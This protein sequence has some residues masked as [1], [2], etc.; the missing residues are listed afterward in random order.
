MTINDDTQH[1]SDAAVSRPS[2][3]TLQHLD[4]HELVLKLNVRDD[5]PLRAVLRA[6][7][8]DSV[9]GV[10]SS[11]AAPMPSSATRAG[12]VWLVRRLGYHHLR[13]A[14]TGDHYCVFVI[15]LCCFTFQVSW[16]Q[17]VGRCTRRCLAR[18]NSSRP[19]SARSPGT[20]RAKACSTWPTQSLSDT[21]AIRLNA[22]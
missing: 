6:A 19:N 21:T 11:C 18:A 3:G 17:F 10:G 12:S 13:G 15:R 1:G 2:Q 9:V 5:A 7:D 8:S 22:E 16:A 4:P 20:I 14:G